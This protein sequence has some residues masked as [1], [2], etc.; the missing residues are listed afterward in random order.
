M[1]VKK[2]RQIAKVMEHKTQD[3]V[4]FPKTQTSHEHVYS[5]SRTHTNY[6]SA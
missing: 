6:D 5:E 3:M 4:K 2:V 1:T